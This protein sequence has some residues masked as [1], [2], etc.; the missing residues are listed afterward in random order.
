MKLKPLA[1]RVVIKLVEAEEKTKSGIILTGAAKEKPEVAE[2]IEVGPGGVVDGKE[3]TMTV[4]KGDKVK[5]QVK[6][7]TD[8]G[9]FIG[10]PGGIDGLVHLSDLSWNE[11]GE[12]AVRNFKKG[13]EVEAVVLAIDTERERISLGIKQLS[14]DPFTDFAGSHER[15]TIVKGTVKS[16]DAK[17][18]VIDLG[19]D[20]EGYLRASEISSERVEDA[21]TQLTVGQEVEALITSVDRKNRSIQLS[22][23]AKDA[24]EARKALDRVNSDASAGTTNLG[25]LLKAKL[26][27]K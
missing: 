6:S 16:V 14:G 21:T 9:V 1:D 10:L 4:K 22:I 17:G 3:I 26:E 13:D 11:S 19:N 12:D 25:A 15:N 24:A 27:Q 23:K 18:A 8:F 5:G 7:I 20:T 2:V